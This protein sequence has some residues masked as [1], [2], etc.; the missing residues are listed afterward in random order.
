HPSHRRF[1]RLFF[2]GGVGT[3]IFGAL[4]G[5]WAGNLYSPD[6]LG[7]DNIFYRLVQMI[8]H[9]DPLDK[10]MLML[11]A[12]LGI[13]VANQFYGIILNMYKMFRKHRPLDALFD[14]GLWL[15]FLPGLMLMGLPMFA[16]DAPAWAGTLGKVLAGVGAAG[17]VLTQGRKEKGILLKAITGIVSLYGVLGTYGLTS[18]VGDVLSYSRLLALGFT[19]SIVAMA[20][21][22]IANMFT[23]IPMAGAVVFAAVLAFGHTFNF[24][25]SILSAFVHSARLIFLEFFNR[26]YEGGARPFTPLSFNS[27][28]VELVDGPQ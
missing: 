24:A 26:F 17:L 25:V 15:L 21:N 11:G 27:V 1:F 7:K 5:A 18:F 14:G 4:T 19:T 22:M 9:V 2:Y 16:K 13:G 12:A 3:M 28:R 20:F 8:P 10:P 23:S 6:F